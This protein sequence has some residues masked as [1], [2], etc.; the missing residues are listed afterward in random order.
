MKRSAEG[1]ADSELNQLLAGGRLSGSEY[2]RIEARVLERVRPERQPRFWFALAPATAAASLLGVWLLGRN[3]E[4]PDAFTAKG[5]GDSQRAVIDVGCE[6]PKPHVCRIGQTLMFSVGASERRGYLAAYAERVGVPAASRI[7]Y[8]PA[9]SG[10]QPRVDSSAVTRVLGEGVR[11]GAP[12]AAGRYRV[13]AWI[14]ET[15]V[16][17]G[18][19]DRVRDPGATEILLEIVE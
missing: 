3:A 14:S 13:H 17:R 2:D 7:W 18:V 16:G 6:G 1:F 4:A 19:D 8:F 5:N 10:A 11:L 12:H 9:R 15:P